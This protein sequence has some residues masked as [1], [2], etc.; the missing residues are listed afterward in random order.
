MPRK[1]GAICIPAIP[2][3]AVGRVQ[4][5]LKLSRDYSTNDAVQKRLSPGQIKSSFKRYFKQV[6]GKN[7]S[8]QDKHIPSVEELKRIY[9]YV[10]KGIRDLEKG[11]LS[12]FERSMW[13][14]EELVKR[15]PE[16]SSWYGREGGIQGDFRAK[17]TQNNNSLHQIATKIRTL[18]GE[19]GFLASAKGNILRTKAEKHIAEL[20]NNI[21]S[22]SRNEDW[23]TRDALMKELDGYLKEGEGL[24]L[25]Q[26]HNAI[27]DH[28]T[29]KNAPPLVREAAR[30]W[31]AEMKPN[32]DKSILNGVDAYYWA[33]QNL[34][35]KLHNHKNFNSSLEKIKIIRQRVQDYIKSDKTK[36]D[37]P[38]RMLDIVP[39]LGKVN[40]LY[41][42]R[43]VE[44]A[45]KQ[46]DNLLN[47]LVKNTV[48]MDLSVAS[49]LFKTSEG[50][51]TESM[52]I[53][54]ILD[55]YTR[56]VSRFEM[57]GRSTQ[58]MLQ[59]IQKLLKK[60]GSDELVAQEIESYIDYIK[61]SYV[62]VA[63][64]KEA[65]AAHEMIR[66]LT[67]L[68]AVFKLGLP[69]IKSPAKN[70]TQSF[71]HFVWWGYK[72]MKDTRT[73]MADPKMN[74]R[75]TE[76][77][78]DNNILFQNLGETYEGVKADKVYDE[79]SG[80]WHE[81]IDV[82]LA[83]KTQRSL[84]RMTEKSLWGMTKVE[85]SWNRRSSTEHGYVEKGNLDSAD[86]SLPFQYQQWILKRAKSN[87]VTELRGEDKKSKFPFNRKKQTYEE[88]S[89]DVMEALNN[90][91][92]H[93]IWAGE[94]K[95]SDYEYYYE[96]FRRKSAGRWADERTKFIH[97]D[98]SRLA[99][100]G[101]MKTKGGALVGQFRTWFINNMNYQRKIFLEGKDDVM[102]GMYGGEN[103]WRLYRMGMMNVMALGVLSPLFN[104][105]LGAIIDNNSWWDT[106][107]MGWN[108][109]SAAGEHITEGDVDPETRDAIL[110]GTYSNG[111]VPHLLGV[112]AGDTLKIGSMIGFERMNQEDTL[113]Y[114]FGYDAWADLTGDEKTKE[115]AL[116]LHTGIGRTFT[117]H[118]PSVLTGASPGQIL[119]NEMGWRPTKFQK[120]IKEGVKQRFGIDDKEIKRKL[121]KPTRE[122]G[123]DYPR[124][125]S[126]VLEMML[127]NVAPPG[128]QGSPSPISLEESLR[129]LA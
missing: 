60:K 122:I 70:V 62:D 31:R 71:Q 66:T 123:V 108:V 111:I 16:L 24:V 115:L 38:V 14:S 87:R 127:A 52:N 73:A 3:D 7:I 78:K 34:K 36:N 114:L 94:G 49:S 90:Q 17:T 88:W 35:G 112:H 118:I 13:L 6:T 89:K 101:A 32:L 4:N 126:E 80:L 95:V 25:K 120:G 47:D 119:D 44:G 41:N 125:E 8:R 106:A 113:S 102:A 48:N 69:N 64:T 110:A 97:F 99:K 83:E 56:S 128:G 39:T 93:E 75:I 12:S 129:R 2:A 85:N 18:S 59:S 72:G 50:K 79:A 53:L 27:T 57:V 10:N 82:S 1:S 20:E 74:M 124:T 58:N 28:R 61:D 42:S 40:E 15:S 45:Y 37:F 77:L 51:T 67:N 5:L 121:T 104:V 96:K 98:Y 63:G 105:N 23:S 19:N 68:Q 116:S 100:P 92:T 76:W 9:R 81:K 26:L 107:T 33:H 65:D 55:A 29:V 117:K 43:E 91:K 86:S 30:I 46:A 54:P 84:E 11:K 21:K 103:A 22:A 109:A